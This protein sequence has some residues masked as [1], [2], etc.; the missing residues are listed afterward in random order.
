MCSESPQTKTIPQQESIQEQI[1]ESQAKD[2]YSDNENQE[3]IKDPWTVSVDIH[4]SA[5]HHLSMNAKKNQKL[6]RFRSTKK[7]PHSKIPLSPIQP[8]E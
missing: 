7:T 8:E 5:D 3:N 4:A 6:N 1:V 2:L